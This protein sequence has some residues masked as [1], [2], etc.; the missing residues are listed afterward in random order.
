ML[1]LQVQRLR[2]RKI[3]ESVGF[4]RTGILLFPHIRSPPNPTLHP[5]PREDPKSRSPKLGPYTTKG[6]FI[7]TPFWDLLFGSSRGS[8]CRLGLGG[9]SNMG[10]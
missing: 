5:D 6:Y 7:G 3:P 10:E 9:G 2:F 8:G 1:G 4:C